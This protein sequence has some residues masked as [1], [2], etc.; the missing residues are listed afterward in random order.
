MMRFPGKSSSVNLGAHRGSIRHCTR[1]A[2]CLSVCPTYAATGDEALSPRGRMMLVQA[3]LDG[4]LAASRRVH[5]RLSRCLLCG[6]CAGACPSGV[7]VPGI[8]ADALFVMPRPA[9][10]RVAASVAQSLAGGKHLFVP[11][12]GRAP[13]RRRAFDICSYLCGLSRKSRPSFPAA[14]R[15]SLE[16]VIPRVTPVEGAMRRVAL[17]PGCAAGS[18]YQDSARAAVGALARAGIETCYPRGLS[19]C[20]LP[21]ERLGGRHE[22]ARTARRNL[23][24]LSSSGASAVVTVCSACAAALGRARQSDSQPPVIDVLTLLHES[25]GLDPGKQP[26][27]PARAVTWHE[28]CHA[29]PASGLVPD[30]REIIA[31]LPGVEYVE[32]EET[33]CCGGGG[34]FRLF[35]FDLAL[36][37][38]LGRAGKLAA[39]GAGTVATSC[40]GCRMQLQDMLDRLGAGMRVV[41]PVE[42][43]L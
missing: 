37:I 42:L 14:A 21:L 40:P 5:E 17:F 19:C 16:D 34:I 39:T 27:L 35:H 43:L 11:L 9:A 30:P 7:D 8:V 2:V 4:R 26:A 41:H 1:C 33:G 15:A 31:R 38:G 29:A 13:A 12:A 22:A 28:P 20:G 10:T 18:F 36:A 3:V 24:L 6:A 32:P 25:G 23:E